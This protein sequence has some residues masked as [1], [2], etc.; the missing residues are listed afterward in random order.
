M[1]HV[2]KRLKCIFSYIL[3]PVLVPVE[4]QHYIEKLIGLQSRVDK[5]IASCLIL[6]L[7]EDFHQLLKDTPD[8]DRHSRWGEVRPKIEHDPRYKAVD[9]NARREDW[10]RDY[11]RNLGVS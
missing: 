5:F 11:V 4:I 3:V 6:Q 2:K 10:F 9:S 1:N 7:K 8:I